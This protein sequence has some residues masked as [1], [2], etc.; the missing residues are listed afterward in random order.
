MKTGSHLGSSEGCSGLQLKMMIKRETE[1]VGQRVEP[2][3][4]MTS[5]E[6]S[7][8]MLPPSVP[9]P[10]ST[11]CTSSLSF[12]VENYLPHTMNGIHLAYP[13]QAIYQDYIQSQVRCVRCSIQRM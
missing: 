12:M 9:T 5:M 2:A 6:A 13:Q 1:E 10:P 11:S 4:P 8:P 3:A 7:S